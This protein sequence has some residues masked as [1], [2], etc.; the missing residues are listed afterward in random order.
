M[1]QCNNTALP[2]QETHK[3]PQLG[4][5]RAVKVHVWRNDVYN[6][7][8]IPE[9][10]K[11]KMRNAAAGATN[12]FRNGNPTLHPL[13]TPARHIACRSDINI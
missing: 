9:P 5:C 6:L 2:A 11:A 1:I 7:N 4:T 3:E 13:E 10:G 12:P 8:G